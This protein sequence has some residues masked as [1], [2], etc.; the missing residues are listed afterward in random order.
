MTPSAA[1]EQW[2]DQPEFTSIRAGGAAGRCARMFGL[3]DQASED[4]D[5]LVRTQPCDSHGVKPPGVTWL[6]GCV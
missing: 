3:R 1:S 6:R 5:K 4:K 2:S